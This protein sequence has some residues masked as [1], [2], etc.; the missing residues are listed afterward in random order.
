MDALGD[1]ISSLSAEDIA[2]LQ[3]VASS[4]LQDGGQ[5]AA[6]EQKETP[7]AV[8][9]PLG[10]LQGLSSDDL[11]MLLKLQSVMGRMRAKGSKNAALIAA[12]KPLLSEKSQKK[13]DEAM[14]ILNLFEMLPL[15]R[16]MFRV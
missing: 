5:T 4:V 15:I 10:G 13:A 3:S 9:A 12:L 11:S 14:R 6:N 7:P 1:I 16:D 2:K 8:P